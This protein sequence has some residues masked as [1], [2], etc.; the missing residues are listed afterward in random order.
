MLAVL[1]VEDK[2]QPDKQ[3]EASE[4]YGTTSTAHPGVRYLLEQTCNTYIGGRVSGAQL[5]VH[6]DFETLRDTPE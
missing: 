2:W 6:N 5:P 4:V 1:S 3:R